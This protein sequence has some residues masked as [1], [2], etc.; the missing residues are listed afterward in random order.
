MSDLLLLQYVD[1]GT[2]SLLMQLLLSFL[3]G[4][5]FYLVTIRRRLKGFFNRRSAD[6]AAEPNHTSDEL[7]ANKED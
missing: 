2:G 7:K 3:I 4:V 5:G 6:Q 1:P